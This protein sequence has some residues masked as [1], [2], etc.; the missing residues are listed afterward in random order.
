MVDSSV[1]ATKLRLFIPK[2]TKITRA[3]NIELIISPTNAKAAPHTGRRA[4]PLSTTAS[5]LV[6]QLAETTHHPKLKGALQRLAD[7]TK[8][9]G[10]A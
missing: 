2:L 1:W 8:P 5:S 10:S 3:D 9:R 4:T 7:N 6:L